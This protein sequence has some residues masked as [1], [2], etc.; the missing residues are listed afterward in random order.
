MRNTSPSSVNCTETAVRIDWHINVDHSRLKLTR[1]HAHFHVQTQNCCLMRRLFSNP[2]FR[3]PPWQT[4][5]VCLVCCAINAGLAFG[6]QEI[7]DALESQNHVEVVV[8][9]NTQ[10]SVTVRKSVGTESISIDARDEIWVLSAHQAQK[11]DGCNARC[12]SYGSEIEFETQRLDCSQWQPQSLSDLAFAHQSDPDH[13]TI[14][15]V[16]GNNTDNDWALTR[17]MQFYDRI[18]G[19]CLNGRPPVRLIILAWESQKV[20]PRPCLDYKL[21]STRAVSLGSHIGWLLNELGG[22]RPVLVGYSLGA[23]VVLSTL[24]HL[25]SCGSFASCELQ[26]GFHVAFIAPALEAD[27]ACGELAAINNNHLIAD[28]QIFANRHDRVVLASQLLSRHR[29]DDR[30]VE[31]SLV[32]LADKGRLDASRFQ[33][34]DVTREVRNRHSLGNYI[35]SRTVQRCVLRVVTNAKLE[36]AN[37]IVEFSGQQVVKEVVKQVASTVAPL[38]SNSGATR[39]APSIQR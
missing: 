19:K 16:H 3:A 13:V 32:G 7:D 22:N 31:P 37:Q 39:P 5:V 36:H 30:S 1:L 27:F 23:Q 10:Q 38:E 18:F 35:E 8:P 20:L 11:L 2:A 24:A 34:H 28:A 26:N 12:D 25:E 4:L 14:M 9:S 21:K 29:C 17:G 6:Q 33:L 15:L